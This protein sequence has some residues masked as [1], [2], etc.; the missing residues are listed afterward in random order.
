MGA[1]RKTPAKAATPKK[2]KK[3]DVTT[4]IELLVGALGNEKYELPGPESNRSLMLQ[5]VELALTVVKEN[6][7]QWQSDC[8]GCVDQAI[9]SIR[10]NL[11]DEVADIQNIQDNAE[12]IKKGLE[13]FEQQKETELEA[14][15]TRLEEAQAIHKEKQDLVKEAKK[16]LKDAKDEEK[17]T[18]EDAVTNEEKK[19]AWAEANEQFNRLKDGTD[20]DPK[21]TVKA[22]LEVL[23]EMELDESLLSAAPSALQ[24]KPEKRGCFDGMSIEH[25]H[26]QFGIQ[27][28]ELQKA[29]DEAD[30]K[31]AQCGQ[32]VEAKQAAFDSCVSVQ[33][34]AKA[35]VNDCQAEKTEANNNLKAATKAISD[36]DKNV[37]NAGKN[38]VKA[39][40]EVEIFA[41]VQAAYQWL[42]ERTD[43]Q[44]IEE[45]PAEEEPVEEQTADTTATA[46]EEMEQ[47]NAEAAVDQEHV[48]EMAM[49]E[50]TMEVD[51][52]EQIAETY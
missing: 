32:V 25:V 13:E 2:Q 27:R 44:T 24:K 34:E 18:K 35:K 3:D 45:E 4:K 47:E 5:V 12:G 19:E 22:L 26:E 41:E 17:Q 43:I 52:V 23:N 21:N 31:I 49:E 38:M 8:L 33:D 50:I 29:I 30:T 16:D 1:K 7:H 42:A 36:H 20:E 37:V 48:K 10:K 11:D 9:N 46:S 39:V 40:K 15:S 28:A 6:R 14:A 51:P